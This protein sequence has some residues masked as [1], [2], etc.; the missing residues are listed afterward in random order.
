MRGVSLQIARGEFFALLGPSGCGK[1]TTLRLIGGFEIPTSGRVFLQ[2]RD[3]TDVPP[4]RRA[5]N[6][7][8]QQLALFPH[9]DVFENVAF[10]LR[11]RRLPPSEVTARVRRVLELVE[12]PGFERRLIHQLS[13]GQKQRVAIARALVNEPAVLLLDEPLGSLD[14]KLRQAMQGE[15]KALQ[16][17]VGTTFVYVTHDQGEALAMADRIAVM[18]DGQIVQVGTPEEI[19]THPRTRFVATFIGEANLL[20]GRVVGAGDGVAVI[21][22]GPLQVRAG[23]VQRLVERDAV[24]VVVRPEHVKVGPPAL[25]CEN[26]WDGA[27]QERTFMG[28]MV[29][30]RLSLADGVT[31]MAELPSDAAEGLHPGT[32]IPVGWAVEHGVVLRE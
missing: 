13:G 19:Y 15:L 21:A 8:F 24:T 18:A 22:V 28:S 23:A 10:G 3:V 16:H 17:R 26:H 30:C 5:T 20:D 1:T 31:V 7:V 9:L 11:L 25:A 27:I 4:Y 2:G 29:R 12:L 6:M 32:H 14:L